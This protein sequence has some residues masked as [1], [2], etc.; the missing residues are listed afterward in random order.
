MII[1]WD[2]L[3]QYTSDNYMGLSRSIPRSGL[4]LLD[5]SSAD[6]C[7]V[8]LYGVKYTEYRIHQKGKTV[9]KDTGPSSETLTFYRN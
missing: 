9:L 5:Q 6:D 2:Y 4:T 1:T 3:W 8:L 7:T